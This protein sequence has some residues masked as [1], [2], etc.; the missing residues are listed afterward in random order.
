VQVA[1]ERVDQMWAEL[2]DQ[3]MTLENSRHTD[4]GGSV[5]VTEW[6]GHRVVVGH[7]CSVGVV[8]H[9]GQGDCHER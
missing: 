7:P 6:V 8:R 2:T 1:V 9:R 3:E 4:Q 5:L